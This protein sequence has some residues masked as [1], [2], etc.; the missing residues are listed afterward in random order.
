L[1]AAC[2]LAVVEAFGAYDHRPLS[3]DE[4]LEQIYVLG[5]AP[6]GPSRQR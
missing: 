1:F 6:G 2:G 3:T 5:K 4:Q